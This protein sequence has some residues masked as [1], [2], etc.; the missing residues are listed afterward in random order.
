MATATQPNAIKNTLTFKLVDDEAMELSIKL[1]KA[2]YVIQR[3]KSLFTTSLKMKGDI[4]SIWKS[5][6]KVN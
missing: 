3:G 1:Q 5:G 6:N 4:L 2:I